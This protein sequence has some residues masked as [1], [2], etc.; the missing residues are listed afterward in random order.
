VWQH[1]LHLLQVLEVWV[2][3]VNSV[4]SMDYWTGEEQAELF[5]LVSTLTILEL[6][7]FHN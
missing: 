7:P 1:S 5:I 6:T 4:H 2:T 3:R